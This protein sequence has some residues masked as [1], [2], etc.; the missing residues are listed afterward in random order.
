MVKVNKSA[1]KSDKK[2]SELIE[3]RRSSSCIASHNLKRSKS[4]RES[5]RIIGTKFLHQ[6]HEVTKS[7]SL[8]DIHEQ[9][10]EDNNY[11]K[12]IVKENFNNEVE[13]IL[14]TPMVN[15]K[16]KSNKT[17]LPSYLSFKKVDFLSSSSKRHETP[18]LILSE[19]P[20][21]VAPKAAAI[22][23]IPLKEHCQ[24]VNYRHPHGKYHKSDELIDEDDVFPDDLKFST[25]NR[26]SFRL[27][28][29]TRRRN[30]MWS[31]FSSTSSM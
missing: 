16:Q 20:E 2:M 13:T 24:P 3:R 15:T 27:S 28:I 12:Y 29:N 14:K 25:F 22:L 9:R 21:V 7:P 4:V 18:A 23:E 31:S 10:D 17:Q 11:N 5:L 19:M 1:T 8:S 30:T 26:N 6:R